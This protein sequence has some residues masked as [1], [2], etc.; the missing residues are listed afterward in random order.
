MTPADV[1]EVLAAAGAYDG[2]TV[3][4][5]DVGAWH[6]AIGDLDPQDALAAVVRHY[7]NSTEW[8]KPAHVRQNVLAIRNE[9]AEQREHEVR[10]LPSRFEP[11]P[12]RAARIRRGVEE[13]AKRWS[14]PE[15]GADDP[16]RDAALDRAKRERGKRPNPAT[17]KVRKEPGKALELAKIRGPEWSDP[18][19]RERAAVESL[20]AADRPCGRSLCRRCNDRAFGGS[21]A[22]A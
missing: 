13:I 21:D 20:H 3:G 16:V 6:A 22:A 18:D 5:A 19:A 7:Q 14:V 1:A 4:M 8:M 11:D 12:E 9:R 2:R 10:A 15:K 17:T